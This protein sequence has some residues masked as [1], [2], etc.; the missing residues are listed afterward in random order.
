MV[1]GGRGNS[2]DANSSMVSVDEASTTQ[3]AV[4]LHDNDFWDLTQQKAQSAEFLF[5][6]SLLQ[7]HSCNDDL[8]ISNSAN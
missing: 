5:K 1:N 2:V 8:S 4:N 3:K 6:I 7:L